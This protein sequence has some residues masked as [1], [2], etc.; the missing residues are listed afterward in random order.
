MFMDEV[1]HEKQINMF[2]FD[3]SNIASESEEYLKVMEFALNKNDLL[4]QKDSQMIF[5]LLAYFA[6]VK[7]SNAKALYAKY[8]SKT[9]NYKQLAKIANSTKSD[10]V[11]TFVETLVKTLVKK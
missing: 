8:I 5:E 9:G 6:A 4:A 7:G 11:K 10:K 3:L 2:G 1:W